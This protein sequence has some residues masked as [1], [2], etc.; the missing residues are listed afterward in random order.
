MY[1][2]LHDY[3][4]L[5]SGIAGFPEWRIILLSC[6]QSVENH[7]HLKRQNVTV[8]QRSKP[9]TAPWEHFSN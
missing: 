3:D 1:W 2:V 6:G 7:G 5:V 8:V 4:D 9:Y